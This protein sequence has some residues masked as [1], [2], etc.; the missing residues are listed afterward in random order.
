VT[1]KD[2]DKIDQTQTGE[3]KKKRCNP[4]SKPE[5]DPPGPWDQVGR[6]WAG[7]KRGSPEGVTVARAQKILGG[8]GTVTND[9]RIVLTGRRREA[10]GPITK[11]VSKPI[12]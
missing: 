10:K 1:T 9:P 4:T 6:G 2:P 5:K 7:G 11:R 3:G 8:L 12:G